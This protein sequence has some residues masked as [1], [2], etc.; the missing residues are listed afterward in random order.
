MEST[1]R[2]FCRGNTAVLS[3]RIVADLATIYSIHIHSLIS[4]IQEYS[5][6]ALHYSTQLLQLKHKNADMSRPFLVGHP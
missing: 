5:N 3:Q 1:R 4:E 2:R 6:Y